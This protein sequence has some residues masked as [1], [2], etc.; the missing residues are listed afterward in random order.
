MKR[1]TVALLVCILAAAVIGPSLAAGRRISIGEGADAIPVVIVSGSPYQMGYSYGQLMRSDI[2]PCL[3]K[4]M[5]RTGF[6]DA[7]RYSDFVLDAAWAA[8]EPHIGARFIKEMRGVADGAGVSYDLVRRAH[9][10][11]IVEKL[12][13]SAIAVWGSATADGRLYQIRNLEYTMDAG[14]QDHPVIVVY[15][16]ERGIAHANVAFAGFVGSLA[17]MNA[18]GIALSEIGGWDDM[19]APVD[20]AGVPFFVMFRDILQDASSLD[21]ALD[22]MQR[23]KRIKKYFYVIGD[24]RR[25]QAVA[26]EASPAR[27]DLRTEKDFP[28]F[29][30]AGAP[31][32]AVIAIPLDPAA[33]AANR[34]RYDSARLIDLCRTVDRGFTLLSVVYDA[35]AR[36]MWVAY[37]KGTN[38]SAG[39][40]AY[41]HFRLRDYLTPATQ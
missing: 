34:G 41:A 1:L 13:C 10:M 20:F 4:Y 14:L 35:T 33:F 8:V 37:A 16:P 6:G 32:N 38:V 25:R 39:K 31:P 12:A 15:L 9:C 5:A 23:A 22:M 26:I 17:G 21:A 40:R 30:I 24:G 29:S 3:K 11:S 18:Q 2:E 19:T 36:E 7:F 28:R 27:L